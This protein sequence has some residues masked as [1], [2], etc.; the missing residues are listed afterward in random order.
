[1]K[2]EVE[3]LLDLVAIPSVSSVGNRPVIDYALKRLNPAIWKIKLHPYRDAKGIA[4]VNL[5][6]CP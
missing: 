1:M 6:G 3:I 5:V 2:D 4:K